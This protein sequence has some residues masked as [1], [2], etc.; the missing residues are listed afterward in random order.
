[1]SSS[2][3]PGSCAATCSRDNLRPHSLTLRRVKRSQVI[4]YCLGV[5]TIYAAAGSP[6]HDI[7]EH[8]LLSMHMTQ[9]LLFTLVAPPLLLAGIPTWLWEALF[10]G[11][12]SCR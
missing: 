8:Y 6:I 3:A 4:Y 5:F 10:G 9:H 11:A 7:S 2:S 12:G 1:M